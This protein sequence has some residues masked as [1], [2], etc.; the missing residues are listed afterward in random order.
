MNSHK[1]EINKSFA[2]WKKVGILSY[3]YSAIRPST[4]PNPHPFATALICDKVH[5]FSYLNALCTTYGFTD[6]DKSITRRFFF[7]STSVKRLQPNGTSKYSVIQF[8]F[9][10]SLMALITNFEL[11]KALALF[12]NWQRGG[13]F[14]N[15]IS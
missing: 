10:K 15:G 12:F 1:V 8:F 2:L 11:F 4:P 7:P 6:S 13:T 3:F 14:T 5:K 9:I